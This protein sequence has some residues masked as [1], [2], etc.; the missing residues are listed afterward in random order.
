MKEFVLVPP[1]PDRQRRAALRAAAGMLAK[2]EV[3][4]TQTST[5]I[6]SNYPV[7]KH[8]PFDTL[9]VGSVLAVSK[10]LVYHANKKRHCVCLMVSHPGRYLPAR[11]QTRMGKRRP[12]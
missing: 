1:V 11:H 7:G 12:E 6:D 10:A 8:L 2:K 5:V 3:V 9:T 4:T